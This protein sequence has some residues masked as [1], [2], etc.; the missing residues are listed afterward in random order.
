MGNDEKKAI[1]S[2]M[3]ENRTFAP[4]PEIT[5][6]AHIK[7]LEEHEKM[8]KASIETP[9]AFWLEQA[10][11]LTWSKFPTKSLEYNWNTEGRVIE[12]TWF[13]DGQLNVSVNC[14]DRHLGTP[15]ENKVA[16]IWQGEPEDD[17]VKITYKELHREVCKCANVLKSLGVKR[18]DRVCI[19]L[20]MI[21]ELPVVMLAC[22]RPAV[23]SSRRC[24]AT[25]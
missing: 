9:D 24:E 10:K 25:L 14:L 4:P 8:W 11:S 16:L 13:K 5:K 20:P 1:S 2:L 22:T 23:T 12:H 19:Y 18:G 6:D 3:T 17:V 7:S 21:I 15:R